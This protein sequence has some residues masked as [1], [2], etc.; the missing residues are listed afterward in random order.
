MGSRE[1]ECNQFGPVH[2]VVAG[3]AGFVPLHA[4]FFPPLSLKKA[5]CCVHWAFILMG[6]K[7]KGNKSVQ[8]QNYQSLLR[9]PDQTRLA[10]ERLLTLRLCDTALKFIGI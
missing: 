1:G 5:H 7:Q 3:D 10:D 4:V 9:R 8:S 6:V 2:G